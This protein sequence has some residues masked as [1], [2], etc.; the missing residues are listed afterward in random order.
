MILNPKDRSTAPIAGYRELKDL[1]LSEKDSAI[2]FVHRTAGRNPVSVDLA[3]IRPASRYQVDALIF[4]SVC[5]AVR[6]RS[7]SVHRDI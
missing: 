3:V 4:V 7:K 5:S 1:K 6:K 2:E